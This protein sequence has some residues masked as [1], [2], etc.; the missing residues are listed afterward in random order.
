M[1]LCCV[2]PISQVRL[3]DI[4][5]LQCC[6]ASSVRSEWLFNSG[7]VLCRQQIRSN[8]CLPELPRFCCICAPIDQRLASHQVLGAAGHMHGNRCVLRGEIQ[9]I[10]KMYE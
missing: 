6:T 5:S 2:R 10:E 3:V 8:E 7:V 4:P 1:P 9:S